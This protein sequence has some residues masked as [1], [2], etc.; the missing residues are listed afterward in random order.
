MKITT[1]VQLVNIFLVYFWEKFNQLR[2]LLGKNPEYNVL[3][4]INF[5]MLEKQLKIYSF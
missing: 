5:L 4:N 2:K 3:I 1:F